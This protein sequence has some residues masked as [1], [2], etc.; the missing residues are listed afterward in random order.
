[1][2]TRLLL[3]LL[4]ASVGA[5]VA[6]LVS[7]LWTRREPPVPMLDRLEP[8][9]AQRGRLLAA[10]QTFV[11][12][13][14]RA[15]ARIAELRRSLAAE[16]SGDRPDRSRMTRLVAQIAEIQAEM[17]PRFISYL[18]DMHGVLRSDQRARL[19]EILRKGGPGVSACPAAALEPLADPKVRER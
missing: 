9:T 15:H 17:R 11:A 18:L 12:E 4:T 8:E 1:M 14:A 5:N 13:R 2:K 3:L 6:F 10:R 19:A 7:T 16:V